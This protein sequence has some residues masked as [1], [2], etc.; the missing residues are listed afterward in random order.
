MSIGTPFLGGGV[1]WLNSALCGKIVFGTGK[2]ITETFRTPV[3]SWGAYVPFFGMCC[4]CAADIH[5]LL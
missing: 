4:I 2:M 5:C 1:H 3:D